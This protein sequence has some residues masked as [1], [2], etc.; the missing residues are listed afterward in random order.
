MR[1]LLQLGTVL[2]LIAAFIVPL[3]ELFDTW[4]GPGLSNDTEYT[5]Y[6]FV[7]GICL[8]LLVCKLLSSQ[9][10]THR[11]ISGRVCTDESEARV[12]VAGC[13]FVFSVPPPFVLPLRI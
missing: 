9:A 11:F 8:V 7:F 10:L 5:V 6:A 12:V 4:D 2:L 3:F 13:G 1:R